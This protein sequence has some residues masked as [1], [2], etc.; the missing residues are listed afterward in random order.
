MEA[1]KEDKTCSLKLKCIK[2]TN[3]NGR[4]VYS[5]LTFS[6]VNPDVSDGDMYEVAGLIGRL[7]EMTIADVIRADSANLVAE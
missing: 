3:E 4:T 1:K 7:Q 2:G 5:M 6:H